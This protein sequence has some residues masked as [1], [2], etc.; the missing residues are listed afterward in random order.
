MVINYERG[1]INLM[2]DTEKVAYITVKK[3][4][5][6]GILDRGV[7]IGLITGQTFFIPT[8]FGE[9]AELMNVLRRYMAMRPDYMA[10]VNP[11]LKDKVRYTVSENAYK[12]CKMLGIVTF[13]DLVKH[14]RQELLALPQIGK[15]S[16]NEFDEALEQRCLHF[17]Y[18]QNDDDH[19][20]EV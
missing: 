3:E 7:E 11:F 16:V 15:K 8:N 1:Y 10:T 5:K 13:E 6:S 20:T 14:T 2:L 19:E 18:L 17:G 4:E 12:A 9:T